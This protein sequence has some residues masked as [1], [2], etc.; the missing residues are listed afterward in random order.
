MATTNEVYDTVLQKLVQIGATELVAEIEK[1]RKEG[2]AGLDGQV[3]ETTTIEDLVQ[4][5]KLTISW[6]EPALMFAQVKEQ[7]R[8]QD[9]EWA[10]DYVGGAPTTFSLPS[11]DTRDLRGALSR[12]KSIL[13]EGIV[14]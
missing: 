13:E 3:R 1:S 4:A 8:S 14:E 6:L 5:T 11:F 7:L 12:L 2:I 9:A 10:T